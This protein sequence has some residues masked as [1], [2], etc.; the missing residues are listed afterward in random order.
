MDDDDPLERQ[1]WAREIGEGTNLDLVQLEKNLNGGI[2]EENANY[3]TASF[4]P[5]AAESSTPSVD[6]VPEY[7]EDTPGLYFVQFAISKKTPGQD[8]LKVFINGKE[9]AIDFLINI[10]NHL[11]P[12]ADIS[13][14][15]DG[16]GSTITFKK[17]DLKDGDFSRLH[18][19]L[20]SEAL[21]NPLSADE[22]EA[23]D[24]FEQHMTKHLAGSR[25]GGATPG[26][27]D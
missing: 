1:R 13:N 25:S 14:K 17:T 8:H 20:R 18:E 7:D 9:R 19:A 21:L 10:R 12:S 23:L 15:E 3:F 6:S 16:N 24:F 2:T 5:K 26:T 4:F 22:T 27:P 11:S